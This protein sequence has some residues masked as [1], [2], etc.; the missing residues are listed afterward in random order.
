MVRRLLEPSVDRAEEREFELCAFP[1][2]CN[3]A[4]SDAVNPIRYV[5]KYQAL[6]TR[7]DSYIDEADLYEADISFYLAN[8]QIWEAVS[9]DGD[10]RATE[11]PKPRRR[12]ATN[13][14]GCLC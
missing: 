7:R 11:A 14:R 13:S 9:A 6:L 8:L 10:G 12:R 5:D 2:L 4:N 1:T 3:S